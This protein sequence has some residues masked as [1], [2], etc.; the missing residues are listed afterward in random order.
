MCGRTTATPSTSSSPSTASPQSTVSS[1]E[2][3][4]EE[5]VLAELLVDDSPAGELLQRELHE[6]RRV[7][8]WAEVE[9]EP[10]G[11]PVRCW[12]AELVYEAHFL[13]HAALL[14]RLE[15]GAVTT[16]GSHECNYLDWVRGLVSMQFAGAVADDDF[17]RSVRDM[18]YL[19]L[20]FAQASQLL[21]TRRIAHW[22][23]LV[24]VHSGGDRPL[25]AIAA[26][27]AVGAKPASL[28]DLVQCSRGLN[29]RTTLAA[30]ERIGVSLR[31]GCYPHLATQLYA[32][33]MDVPAV[34]VG[35]VGEEVEEEV[36]PAAGL[37]VLFD[38]KRV[39][40][41]VMP[42]RR[43]RTCLVGWFREEE[44]F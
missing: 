9:V 24:Q 2:L 13:V 30:I 8:V 33:A 25:E 5:L 43:Q 37:L 39:S 10:E 35:A 23:R 44:R 14:A 17:V 38:S 22:A 26:F 31:S 11:E 18:T 20:S 15:S 28:R 36:L 27:A 19:R 6:L 42:T 32:S 41:E 34:V 3:A 1:G 12:D 40:H 29:P 21:C 4:D 7:E 16:P